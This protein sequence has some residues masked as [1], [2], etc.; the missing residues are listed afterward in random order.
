MSLVHSADTQPQSNRRPR[1][2]RRGFVQAV[3]VVAA[4]LVAGAAFPGPTQA[5]LS[6]G[7]I[8]LGV[9]GD[10]ESLGGGPS[11]LV[12]DHD[13][14]QLEARGIPQARMITVNSAATWRQV[15]DA[16]AGSAIHSNLVRWARELRGR[17]PVLLAYSHEPETSG[18]KRKGTAADFKA[19]FR[20]VV[21]VMR[22]NGAGNVSFTWQM[23]AWAFRAAP[24]D[25][26]HASKWYPGN[27]VVD[28]VGADA[29]NW[30]SCGEGRGRWM[31]LSQIAGAGLDFA[32]ARKKQFSLP[33]FGSHAGSQRAAW[34]DRAHSWMADNKKWFAGAYYFNR[35]P[36]NLANDDCSWPLRTTAE[37]AAFRRMA[38]N[39][40]LFSR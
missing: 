12:G 16:R 14:A 40:A 26:I 8:F 38:E 7:R 20:K 1:R 36:T 31:E 33:E 10:A 3:L 6:G 21:T 22:S 5:T 34:I 32:I 28:V 18:N 2:V 25:R 13:Y 19:A 35:P 4:A 30:H 23:T 15:A 39:R 9:A 11:G 27:D 24:S 37:K 17:G 29:Y